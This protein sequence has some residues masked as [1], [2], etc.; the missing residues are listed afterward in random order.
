[1]LLR[2]ETRSRKGLNN[3]QRFYPAHTRFARASFSTAGADAVRSGARPIP[4][5]GRSVDLLQNEYPFLR[6]TAILSGKYPGVGTE[7]N[8]VVDRVVVDKKSTE[9]TILQQPSVR[10][11]LKRPTVVSQR[12]SLLQ[13]ELCSAELFRIPRA[14]QVSMLRAR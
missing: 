3:R 4:I 10:R 13:V 8:V 2:C 11:K 7:A 6:K 14:D 5:K 12:Q 1:M 9:G